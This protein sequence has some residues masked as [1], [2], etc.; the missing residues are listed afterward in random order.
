MNQTTT[1]SRT[2]VR[3]L[4]SR[5]VMALSAQFLIGMAVYGSCQAGPSR[6]PRP[7]ATPLT[8]HTASLGVTLVLD[9]P[10]GPRVVR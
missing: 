1:A 10:R 3:H 2:R 7:R 9:D 5:Q 8:R 6:R 4:A